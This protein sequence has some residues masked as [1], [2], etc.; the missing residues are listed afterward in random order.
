MSKNVNSILSREIVQTF[1]GSFSSPVKQHEKLLLIPLN[2][3]QV[4]LYALVL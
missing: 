2:I 1:A 3:E 4:G